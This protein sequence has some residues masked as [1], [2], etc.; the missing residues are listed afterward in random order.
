MSLFIETICIQNGVP[1]LLEYHQKRLDKT[2]NISK[3]LKPKINLSKLIDCPPK[4]SD[5]LVKCTLTY[6]FY[7]GL[8]EG[9]KYIPY[10]RR[11]IN[12]LRKIAIRKNIYPIKFA[13]RDF[14]E[15]CQKH[16]AVQP[17]EEIVYVL[18]GLISDTTYTNIAL[19]DGTDYFT[20]RI[21]MLHGTRR[22]FL[23]D[24]NILI[25][26]DIGWDQLKSFKEVHLINAMNGIG[27]LVIEV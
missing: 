22:Q 5:Q 26:R 12:R 23:I 14:F 19:F 4:L 27:D 2:C 6:D 1:Q 17:N 15:M 13:D 21:P 8:V 10:Q 9:I 25:P 3:L 24:Q 18:K 20:P 16:F 7:T 11:T